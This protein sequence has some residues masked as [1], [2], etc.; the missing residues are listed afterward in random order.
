MW[1]C[2]PDDFD[3]DGM[4]VLIVAT[5]GRIVRHTG[6]P[7]CCFP[8]ERGEWR[9]RANNRVEFIYD[10]PVRKRETLRW[11]VRSGLFV[12]RDGSQYG[13]VTNTTFKQELVLDDDNGNRSS[14]IYFAQ[15]THS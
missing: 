14:V 7:V 6:G 13:N 8:E 11:R 2:Y 5:N 4:N 15:V 10:E 9:V 1:R 3:Y 12:V